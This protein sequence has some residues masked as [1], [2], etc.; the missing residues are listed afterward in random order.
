MQPETARNE[1][2]KELRNNDWTLQAIADKYGISRERVRQ[3][4]GNTSFTATFSKTRK[5]WAIYEEN[6]NESN[7]ALSKMMG[8]SKH[9]VSSIFR[10]YEPIRHKLDLGDVKKGYETENIVSQK[11][12]S[13]G[14][15]NTLM[16]NFHPFDMLLDNGL[17]VDVKSSNPISCSVKTSQYS[18]RTRKYEKG[19]YCDFFILYLID[20]KEFFVVPD[21]VAGGIIRF[22]FPEAI[23]GRKSKWLQ[24]HNRFDLLKG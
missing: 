11:L 17:K 24:Y 9:R 6:K 15:K 19:N 20:V 8:I 23:H 2:M 18:F 4:I 21:S 13:L 12:L 10:R 1:E 22:A 7:S 5:N 16:P 3:I 14:I